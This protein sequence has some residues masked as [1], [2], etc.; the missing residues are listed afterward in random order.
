LTR[1]I[2]EERNKVE[3]KHNEEEFQANKFLEYYNR[4]TCLNYM[5][6]C[7]PEDKADPVSNTVRGT[8]DFLLVERHG[9]GVDLAVEIGGIYICEKDVRNSS[10]HGKFLREL[11]FELSDELA[12]TQL[13]VFEADFDR[14]PSR[15]DERA[16]CKGTLKD[17]FKYMMSEITHTD[18]KTARKLQL[19]DT[20]RV[21]CSLSRVDAT[22]PG[23]WILSNRD[24]GYAQGIGTEVSNDALLRVILDNNG[25]LAIPKEE[26][27]KTILLAV[28][29]REGHS[30]PEPNAMKLMVQERPTVHN[31]IDEIYLLNR[32]IRSD[33]FDVDKIK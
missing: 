27:K 4:D 28:N 9:M 18:H 10:I 8:Y 6:K 12:P 31:N 22:K 19:G 2:G 5:I 33:N 26:G 30:F 14:V 13:Y 20:L 7:R 29:S 16:M 21:D 25:K 24:G 32:K 17:L 23:I 15:R 1:G 11:R 3:D